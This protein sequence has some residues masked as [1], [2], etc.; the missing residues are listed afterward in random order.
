MGI[1]QKIKELLGFSCYEWLTD[2]HLD[3][4]KYDGW[5]QVKIY[6]LGL[7][8]ARNGT[9]YIN[10]VF[11]SFGDDTN[12]WQFS[13]NYFGIGENNCRMGESL[14][15]ATGFDQLDHQNIAELVGKRIEVRI[16]VVYR[17]DR[18]FIDV[19]DHRELTNGEIRILRQSLHHCLR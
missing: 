17:Q 10:V 16:S 5:L 7:R 6:Q 15:Q 3:S 11:R 18:N 19:I 12:K 14:A 13:H 9:D 1:I 2:K 4:G 8:E